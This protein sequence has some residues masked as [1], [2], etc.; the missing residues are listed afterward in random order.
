MCIEHAITHLFLFQSPKPAK[1]KQDGS[2]SPGKDGRRKSS[3]GRDRA[4]SVKSKGSNMEQKGAA[5]AK[6]K[7]AICYSK[8]FKVWVAVARDLTP[9]QL[10]CFDGS[11][12]IAQ[13][14]GHRGSVAISPS[15]R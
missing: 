5:S 11:L 6:G 1:E 15:S 2:K 8:P 9:N 10:R 4:D 12:E 14:L 7:Y 13:Y 3:V